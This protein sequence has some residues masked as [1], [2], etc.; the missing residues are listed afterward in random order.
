M[1]GIVRMIRKF[2]QPSSV[3]DDPTDRRDM[4]KCGAVCKEFLSG[5]FEH[6]VCSNGSQRPM[7]RVYSSDSTPMLINSSWRRF[8]GQRLVLRKGKK[9]TDFLC[10]RT[11]VK[12]HDSEGRV[13]SEVLLREPLAL[14]A[15]KTGWALF[16]CAQQ[17][18]PSLRQLGF[19]GPAVSC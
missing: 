9:C 8:L 17:A 5:Q 6:L 10:E 19:C 14:T 11:F 18:S 12:G 16:S 1:A 15:G 13:T 7:T 4:F 3:I 2:A